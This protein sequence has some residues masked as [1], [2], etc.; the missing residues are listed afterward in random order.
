VS[1]KAAGSETPSAPEKSA[2]SETPSISEKLNERFRD[3]SDGIRQRADLTAKALGGVGTTVLAAIGIVKLGDLWP[4]PSGGAIWAF[5]LMPFSF[6]VMALVLGFF[7]FRLWRLNQPIVLYADVELMDDLRGGEKRRVKEIYD[8]EA[9]LNRA[10]SLAAY[11]ARSYQLERIADRSDDATA[12]RLREAAAGIANDVLA[13][14]AKAQLVVIRERAS[15]AVGDIGALLGYSAFVLAVLVF[16][17]S[18]AELAYVHA[19]QISNAK[20]CADAQKAGASQLPNICSEYVVQSVPTT[21]PSEEVDGAIKTL[22][23]SLDRCR[24]EA[25]RSGTNI[26]QCQPIVEAIRALMSG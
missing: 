23:D 19:G 24:R 21:S 11:V 22:S 10:S 6:L 13:T 5:F 20:S 4:F 26:S 9:R 8:R 2:E 17:V 7:T 16:A 25:Q 3:S 18:A 15:R 14:E 1:D 12:K